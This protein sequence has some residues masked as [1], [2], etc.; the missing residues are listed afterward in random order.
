MSPFKGMML[1]WVIWLVSWWGAAFWSDRAVKGAGATPQLGYNLLTFGG[2]VLLFGVYSAARLWSL[3][4]T[5]G[6]AMLVLAAAGF[7]FSWWARLHLGR[8]WARS[9]SRKADHQVIDTGP[10][11]LVRHPIYTGIILATLATA[12]L[13]GTWIAWAGVVV[14]TCG[15]YVKA[16]LEERFLRAELGEPYTAYARRV[17]MLVPFI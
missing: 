8:F 4:V 15:W 13:K 12:A 16:R 7:L 1:L 10:Y 2:G 9:V 3:P 11:A 5:E 6:W 14:M 17:P